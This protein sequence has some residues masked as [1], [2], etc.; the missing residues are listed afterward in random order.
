MWNTQN[1]LDMS[2]YWPNT[3]SDEEFRALVNR[4]RLIEQWPDP[5]KWKESKEQL[6]DSKPTNQ[7][8]QNKA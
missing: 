4:I 6:I 3:L 8:A 2:E 7:P 5:I 1:G